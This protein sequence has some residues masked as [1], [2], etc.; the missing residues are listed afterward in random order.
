MP[1]ASHFRPHV[2]TD[3]L[4]MRA[5]VT[6]EGIALSADDDFNMYKATAPYAA[7]ELVESGPSLAWSTAIW[8]RLMAPRAQAAP[9]HSPE[10]RRLGVRPR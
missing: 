8:A 3:I 10:L 7:R 5:F 9:V 4:V 2:G 1:C 6:L